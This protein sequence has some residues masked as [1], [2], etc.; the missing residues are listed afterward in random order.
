MRSKPQ[1]KPHS[2]QLAR[3]IF[4]AG[5][6]LI[7]Q[8]LLAGLSLPALAEGSIVWNNDV[9]KGLQEA[10]DQHKYVLAD[11]YTD[12]CVWCKRLDQQTFSNDGM[13][14]YLNGK[15]V[16]IKANAEDHKAGTKLAQKYKVSG[17]P[18]ALVFDQSGK[19]IGKI[20]GFLPPDEYQAQITKLI[21][22]PPAQP[23]M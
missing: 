17:Y 4:L 13:A 16:C 22:N 10:K 7:L 11:V 12:W 18:C 1:S 9:D 6:L 5:A 2:A 8:V 21:E 23:E 20:V 19:Y 15:F 3:Q 14:A